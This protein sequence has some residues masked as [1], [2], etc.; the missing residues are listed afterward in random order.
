MVALTAADAG[1]ASSPNSRGVMTRW[2]NI[3][4]SLAEPSPFIYAATPTT[5]RKISLP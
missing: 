5:M 1:A 3:E 4:R 2:R